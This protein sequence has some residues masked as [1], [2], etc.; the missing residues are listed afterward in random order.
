M[1]LCKSKLKTDAH[2][3]TRLL[4]RHHGRDPDAM[5]EDEIEE[6]NR[7]RLSRGSVDDFV[8]IWQAM[9]DGKEV[10]S[11]SQIRSRTLRN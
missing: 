1:G 3:A 8:N 9:R 6:E 2:L 5:D 4:L 7:S 10:R 11:T